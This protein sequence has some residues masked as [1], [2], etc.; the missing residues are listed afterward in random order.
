MAETIEAMDS[1]FFSFSAVLLAFALKNII[2]VVDLLALNHMM[3]QCMRI[4][5]L[6]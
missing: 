3:I 1:G 5:S 6:L 2:S 4:H